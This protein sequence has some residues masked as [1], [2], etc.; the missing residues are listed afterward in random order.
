MP[1]SSPRIAVVDY[2]AGNLRSVAKALERSALAV[3]VT[4]DAAA[5]AHYDALV[6][7]G[8]GAFADAMASLRAKGI[9][10]ALVR[11]IAGGKPYL[12][13]CLGLQV[14]F[15]SSDE[16]GLTPG[17]GVLRG[18]V[19]RFPAN[20]PLHVPH[21]GWNQVRWRGD[22]PVAR[23]MPREDAYYYVHSYRVVD[24]DPAEVAGVTDYGGEFTSAVARG[25]V[26][27]VQFH[28][29]KSQAAGKRLLDAFAAWVRG[30]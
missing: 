15:E 6:V 16:H 12:G 1:T 7:P 3:E 8:V 11:A 26:F 23:Q 29:E 17:L 25:N 20:H 13:L 2:G 28:P 21:I 27:A 24:A 9:G 19:E 4:S 18:R 10:D 14:L 30:C 22:H 5:L